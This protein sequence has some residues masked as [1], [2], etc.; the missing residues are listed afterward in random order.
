LQ[1][2][3]TEKGFVEYGESMIL[4]A[5]AWNRLEKRVAAARLGSSFFRFLEPLSPRRR[6]D[7]TV[8][9]APLPGCLR[10]EVER[11]CLRRP[12]WVEITRL[13]WRGLILEPAGRVQAAVKRAAF[14]ALRALRET[15][16]NL[17]PVSLPAHPGQRDGDADGVALRG[18][19][20][21]V[22]MG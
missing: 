7:N 19:E 12:A 16:S 5:F 2:L 13:V 18:V 10:L 11:S 3:S 6:A 9:R 14:A 1:D 4:L 17:A 22:A 15:R 20:A 8:P 21:V